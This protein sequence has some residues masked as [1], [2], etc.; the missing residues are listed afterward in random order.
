M[1][2]PI[3]LQGNVTGGRRKGR[4]VDA[5]SICVRERGLCCREAAGSECVKWQQKGA[6]DKKCMGGLRNIA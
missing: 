2:G 5:G 3:L 1:P 6:L 4:R